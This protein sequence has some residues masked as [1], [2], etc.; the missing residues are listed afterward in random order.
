[1][2]RAE[3]FPYKIEVLYSA[4]DGCYIARV[5]SLRGCAAHGATPE[6]ATAEVHVAAGAMLETMRAQG[7]P[8]PPPDGTMQT[9]SQQQR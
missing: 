5:P 8:I 2:Q 1:M 7:D 3:P 6:E 9:E 4:A